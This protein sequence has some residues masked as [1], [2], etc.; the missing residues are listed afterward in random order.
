MAQAGKY[1]STP[2]IEEI[3]TDLLPA[4]V[5]PHNIRTAE[6]NWEVHRIGGG[7]SLPRMVRDRFQYLTI[8]MVNGDVYKF[9]KDTSTNQ[10]HFIS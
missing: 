4:T 7:Y 3:V 9:T 5:K 1:I 10:I 2:D 6:W 8:T